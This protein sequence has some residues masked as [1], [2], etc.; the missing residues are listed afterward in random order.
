ML[1]NFANEPVVRMDHGRGICP[2]L[3]ALL[4]EK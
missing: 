1:N 2:R 3:F 4:S